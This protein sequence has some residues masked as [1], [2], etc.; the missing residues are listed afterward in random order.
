MLWKK[1]AWS[2]FYAVGMWIYNMNV[3]SRW[4]GEV[5]Y[6]LLPIFLDG[7]NFNWLTGTWAFNEIFF[8]KKRKKQVSSHLGRQYA[9]GHRR[10]ATCSYHLET[11]KPLMNLMEFFIHWHSPYISQIRARKGINRSLIICTYN[12]NVVRKMSIMKMYRVHT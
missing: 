3:T 9:L 12:Y 4:G 2:F 7:R 10:H 8:V 1:I 5:C 6:Q 11:S